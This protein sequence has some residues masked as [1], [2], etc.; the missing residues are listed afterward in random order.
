MP[1]NTFSL[2]SLPTTTNTKKVVE[3]FPFPIEF[4]KGAYRD[5]I[6]IL[7]RSRVQ[8]LHKK[9][10]TRKFSFVW[11]SSGWSNRDFAYALRL[12]LD[13]TQTPY[14]YVEKN[15]SK[16]TDCMVFALN[17]LPMPDTIFVN[18]SQIKKNISLIKKTC[19]FPL[20]IKDIRGSQGKNSALVHNKKELLES[21]IKLPKN[22]KF[23]FQKYISNDYDW[24]IMV[25]NGV[26]VSGEKSYPS[27]GEFRNNA[28]NGAKEC[29]IAIKDIPEDIKKLAIEASRS[30]GL[31][32][33][34]ADIIIDKKTK[35]PYLLE[36]N[37]YPGITSGSNEVLGAYTFL[38]SHIISPALHKIS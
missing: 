37:R 12:Y 29:F 35:K 28:C 25:A 24:G 36:V 4:T 17:D 11:L 26:V 31:S 20:V 38:S 21:M 9:L 8:V 34:R 32:W 7:R 3:K 14:S 1:K 30:L 23:I 5:I 15:T 16:I 27:E 22:K 19:G 33:S 10:D 6:F 13:S 2:L 18:R